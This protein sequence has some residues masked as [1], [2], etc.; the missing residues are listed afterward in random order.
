M[1]TTNFTIKEKNGN[2]ILRV[3]SKNT[4][5][6]MYACGTLFLNK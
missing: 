2:L 6:L 1:T 5:I 3:T 4:I